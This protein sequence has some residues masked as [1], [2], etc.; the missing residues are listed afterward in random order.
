MLL[1][2]TP[3]L[4]SP[5]A[6]ECPKPGFRTALH[7]VL[8]VGARPIKAVVADLGG[9]GRDDLAVIKDASDRVSV[10]L[11]EGRGEFDLPREF[12]VG[13]RPIA[14]V[15]GD[16]NGDGLVDLVSLNYMSG[17]LSVLINRGA[18]TFDSERRVRLGE[19]TYPMALVA[20]DFDRDG[21]LDLAVTFQ[22]GGLWILTGSG[23]GDFHTSQTFVTPGYWG[24]AADDFNA[25]GQLDLAVV[26]A[27]SLTILYGLG[28]ARFQM[29]PTYPIAGFPEEVV[30]GDFNSDGLPDL[31]VTV[32][33]GQGISIFLADGRGGFSTG[34]IPGIR[35]PAGLLVGDFNRD[36]NLDLAFGNLYDRQ[37]IFIAPG[38][39]AGGFGDP[40]RFADGYGRPVGIGDFSGNGSKDL[41]LAKINGILLFMENP[42]GGF[43]S[44]E[45]SDVRYRPTSVVIADFNGDGIRDLT[46]GTDYS[47]EVHLLLGQATGGF[48]L[49]SSVGV[50]GPVRSLAVA[51]LDSDGRPDLVVARGR[52]SCPT[53]IGVPVCPGP[54]I[55]ILL[56]GGEEFEI[57]K[58]IP[59]EKD[60][61][62]V[63]V[64]DFNGDGRMDVAVI[65]PASDRVLILFGTASGNF[66]PPTA[67]A[68]GR[69]PSTLV[70]ADF[71]G[72]GQPDLA[73]ANYASGDVSILLG[74]DDGT[75]MPAQS[76][77]GA[78]SAEGLVAIIAADFDRD[79]RTDLAVAS[80]GSKSV[81]LRLGHGDG[82][83]GPAQAFLLPWTPGALAV[84]DFNGDGYPDVAVT[85][86]ANSK[87]NIFQDDASY[88]TILDFHSIGSEARSFPVGLHPAALAEG[89]L[90]SDGWV[91]LVTAN[92]DS[93]DVSVLRNSCSANLAPIPTPRG[94]RT[95]RVVKRALPP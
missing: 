76:V 3:G 25:D 31:A 72:D 6:G 69:S 95:P 56:S 13:S 67:Y 86:A 12:P 4:V 50:G 22:G 11:N 7:G 53:P 84:G 16:F 92:A 40:I 83:F 38:N 78:V 74:R 17:D 29:G 94:S 90:N 43:T 33:D 34:H 55:V 91:D 41:A 49:S 23:N 77:S 87:G 20:R 88:V 48:A 24:V 93:D 71:N 46:V 42:A 89:D 8:P 5:I 62:T 73:V 45:I 47:S 35:Y 9:K 10:L 19:R 44:P 70:I 82:S 51:D 27:Q 80:A 32:R 37:G 21:I 36:G 28:D 2:L 59:L 61:A 85:D 14:I 26:N 18:G 64:A 65:D 66:G 39:G 30:V 75:F 58:E 52:G 79:G 1:S 81:L 57:A 63:A 15:A 54:A 60:P 68:V